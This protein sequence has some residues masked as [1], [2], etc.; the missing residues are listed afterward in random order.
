MPDLKPCRCGNCGKWDRARPVVTCD[1][2]RPI[3]GTN[4]IGWCAI[5]GLRHGNCKACQRWVDQERQ[6]EE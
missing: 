2:N 6:G 4:W 5:G 3:G 1:S